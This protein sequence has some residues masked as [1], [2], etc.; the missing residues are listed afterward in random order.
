MNRAAVSVLIIL[1]TSACSSTATASPSPTVTATAYASPTVTATA[2]ASRRDADR[3]CGC[4]PIATPATLRQLVGH[5]VGA[6]NAEGTY[7][8]YSVKAPA[9]WS[10]NGA[11]VLIGDIGLSVWD[12]IQVPTDPCL[13]Q[14]TMTTPGPTVDDLVQALLAQKTRNPTAPRDVTLAGHTGTYLEW[15]IPED[16]VVT[17]DADFE[18]CDDPGN[19]HHDFISWLGIGGSERYHQAAG[20]VDRLWV[21][22]VNGQRLVVDA[23]YTPKTPEA[24]RAELDQIAQSI[25][26]DEP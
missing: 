15:S 5:V 24:R 12:A 9:G 1:L 10:S 22:D 19:G 18:G 6:E 20:Q 16:A 23:T 7:P 8:G 14:S 21:L 2:Y 13:W 17:G 25:R 26:F 3:N 11:F 4:S